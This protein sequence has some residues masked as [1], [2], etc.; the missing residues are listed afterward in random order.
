M[1]LNRAKSF[2]GKTKR[3]WY[4][5]AFVLLAAG[6]VSCSSD[7]TDNTKTDSAG[8]SVKTPQVKHDSVLLDIAS[9]NISWVRE[10]KVKDVKKKIKLGKSTI[11]VNMDEAAFSAEGTI[12][13]A[14]GAWYTADGKL[15]EGL[16]RLNMQELKSLQVDASEHLN[17][18]SPDYMDVKKYPFGYL[19][20]LNVSPVDLSMKD[21]PA[22]DAYPCEVTTLLTIKDKTDTVRFTGA[23]KKGTTVPEMV[24][25]K[26]SI[27]GKAWGLNRPDAK[28]ISDKLTI[29]MK[30]VSKK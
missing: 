6:A 9:C 3:K 27:D 21:M 1:Q 8:D 20:I 15:T 7:S 24:E 18:D 2:S 29:K 11:E 26:F 13:V 19:R 14:G 12:P 22:Q 4:N 5:L 30:L 25:G 10:K 17:M 28:V 23:Y 16:V